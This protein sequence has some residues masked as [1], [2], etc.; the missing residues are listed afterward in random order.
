M[1]AVSRPYGPLHVRVDGSTDAPAVV[2]ANSL[3]TDLRLWDAVL[4]RLG[5]FRFIRYDKRGHGLS[6]LGGGEALADH[7][8]DAIAVI[9]QVARGPV[10]F[11]GLSIGG[12]IAQGVAERRPDL[13]RALVLS[14]TAAK[15]GTAESWQAR[16]AAVQAG[17][18]EAIADAVLD[19]WFPPPFRHG[20]EAGLWRA[21]LV[22]TP[23]DGY[24]AACATLASADQRSA[25]ARL[26]FPVLA[27]AGADDAATPPALV[28]ET[29]AL[30]SGASCHV[31][32]GT[33]HL[34]PID[35]PGAWAD[36]VAPFLKDHAHV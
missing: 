30:I 3:G 29:A 9:E 28:R 23:A 21:M 12:L 11:V 6:A 15:L 26:R 17:G 4:P 1:Q 14:N 35:T 5:P 24:I 22:R 10:V 8:D 34:P 16:I 2:F 7:V 36:L 33:G 13:V 27:I 20:A 31:L 25:T 32:P 19:R 18:L